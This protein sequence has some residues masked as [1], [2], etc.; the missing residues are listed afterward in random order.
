MQVASSL[1]PRSLASPYPTVE[2]T[3]DA[4]FMMETPYS[5]ETSSFEEPAAA[6]LKT[7]EKEPVGWP[8]CIEAVSAGIL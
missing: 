4:P 6:E 7:E 1:R 3:M 5:T 2:S 8:A